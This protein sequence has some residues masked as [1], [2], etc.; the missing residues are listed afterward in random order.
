MGVGGF[1][2]FHDYSACDLL[3]VAI[4]GVLP[5]LPHRLYIVGAAHNLLQS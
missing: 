4:L 5:Y 3:I 1:C 2:E